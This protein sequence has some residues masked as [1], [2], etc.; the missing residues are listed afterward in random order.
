[1]LAIGD[2]SGQRRKVR[3]DAVEKDPRDPASDNTV[4]FT[5]LMAAAKSIRV[6]GCGARGRSW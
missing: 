2:G 4:H 3:I 1:V 6:V 5:I